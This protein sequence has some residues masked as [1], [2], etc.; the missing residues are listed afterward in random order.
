[1]AYRGKM[2]YFI[3]G[4]DGAN[5]YPQVLNWSQVL[6]MRKLNRLRYQ[7][8]PPYFLLDMKMGF[9][10]LFPDI[11]LFPFLLLSKGAMEVAVLYDSEMPYRFTTLFDVEKG[12]FVSYYCPVLE[13]VDCVVGGNA[14]ERKGILLDREK[15]SGI[16]LFY[17]RIKDETMAVI[18]MDLAERLLERDV[19]G[20]ELEE[21]NVYG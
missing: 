19:V 17:I 21:V 10:S 5:P 6:D 11:I 16:P 14:H 1:M 3:L 15:I 12:Q 13:E 7:E 4:R 20:M 18:R 8:L 9:D 2:K